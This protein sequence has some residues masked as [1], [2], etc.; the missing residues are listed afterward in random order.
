[1]Q[2]VSMFS[3][4]HPDLEVYHQIDLIR[5]SGGIFE[6]NVVSLYGL[7]GQSVRVKINPTSDW[8]DVYESLNRAVGKIN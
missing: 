3:K 6:E 4:E 1:M 5:R 8:G 7:S 2:T